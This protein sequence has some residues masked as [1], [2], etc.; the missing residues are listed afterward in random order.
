MS[1]AVHTSLTRV[2][3]IGVTGRMGQALLRAA[4]AFPQLLIT[5]AVA[6]PDSLALGRDVGE[7]IGGGRTNLVVTSDLAAALAHADVALDFST[8]AATAATLRAC[9]AARKPLLLGTTGQGE[10]LGASLEEAAREIALLVAANTS[11]GVTL[12]L[13][14]TRRAAAALPASFDIDVLELH[15]RGKREALSGTAIALGRAAAEGRGMSPVAAWRPA[16]EM[17][18]A[19]EIGFAAVRAGDLVGEHTVLFCGAGEQL[20]LTHRATDRAIFARGAL[21]AALWLA[22]RPP[23]RYGMSEFLGFKTGT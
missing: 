8:A 3:L 6:S 7:L 9:R 23:G 2:A 16:G 22:P 18:G 4:P 19:G 10:D 21:S 15:H 5:G 14:L 1:V 11:V 17:R 12:L 13:E 20:L